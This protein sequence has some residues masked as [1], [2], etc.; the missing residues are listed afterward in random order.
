MAWNLGVGG[1]EI[2]FHAS[3]VHLCGQMSSEQLSEA[4]S[5]WSLL[6]GKSGGGWNAGW[7]E[8]LGPDALSAGLGPQGG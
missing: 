7:R 3:E 2:I 5:W 6:E 4:Q 1:K 8:C